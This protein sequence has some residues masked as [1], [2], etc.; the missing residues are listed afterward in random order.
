M[1]DDDDGHILNRIGE[2]LV[3]WFVT[4]PAFILSS[5]STGF[6]EFMF[7][8]LWQFA[9]QK[10]YIMVKDIHQFLFYFTTSFHF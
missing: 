6:S 10:V 1:D 9:P 7:I 5:F 2:G 8:N 3:S 4:I